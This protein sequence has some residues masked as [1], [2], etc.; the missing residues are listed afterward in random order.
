MDARSTTMVSESDLF[1][2][3]I[4]STWPFSHASVRFNPCTGTQYLIRFS[5]GVEFTAQSKR[6]TIALARA[7]AEGVKRI[8][9]EYP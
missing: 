5:N 8:T 4:Q 3:Q 9:G 6:D 2:R 1:C 7:Y